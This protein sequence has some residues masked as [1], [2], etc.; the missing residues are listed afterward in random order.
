[1]AWFHFFDR[2]EHNNFRAFCMATGR[3][4]YKPVLQACTSFCRCPAVVTY[5]CLCVYISVYVRCEKEWAPAPVLAPKHLQGVL[6]T[7]CSLAYVVHAATLN[8]PQTACSARGMAAIT[9]AGDPQAPCW[10]D[11]VHGGRRL[12]TLPS[13]HLGGGGP[14]GARS[15]TAAAAAVAAAAAAAAVTRYV[16][17]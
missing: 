1:M 9:F 12:T 13:G 7:R 16:W 4:L 10:L 2:A 5:A 14:M 8:M 15:A 11:F 3:A 6:L 17:G